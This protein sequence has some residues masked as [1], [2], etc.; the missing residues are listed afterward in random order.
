MRVLSALLC[1]LLACSSERTRTDGSTDTDGGSDSGA[2]ASADPCACLPG[3]H[4]ENIFVISADGE[5]WRFNPRTLDFTFVVGPVCAGQTPF[6]M[7]V[8]AEG[9]AWINIIDSL[10][11]LNLDLLAPS[12]CTD[13]TYQ[14]R[15]PEFGLFGM[16][17][18]TRSATDV[19]ADLFV[20]TYSGDGSFDEGPD[21]GR[22]GV[23]DPVGG[24]LTP[25]ASNNFDGGELTGTGDGRLFGFAGVAPVKLIEFDRETGGTLRE[26]PL[27]GVR[28]TNS[29]AVAFFGGDIY[30][31][32][33]ATAPECSTCLDAECGA[34]LDACEDDAVCSEH[35]DCVLA[36]PMFSDECGGGLSEEMVRCLDRCEACTRG[37]VARTSRV[38]R[39]DL[40]ESDGGGLSEPVEEAP[41][42]I[43]G[44]AS[45]PCVPVG[46]I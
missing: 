44:A 3:P 21:L 15:N 27:D 24:A 31:F 8:D 41:I 16:S 22:L 25:L 2:D 1:F 45:S 38:L 11:V 4:T 33:E 36:T 28:K 40:D 29:S 10:A 26:I 32:T 46:P 9:V 5:I 18:A 23:I 30:L 42:R 6:S 14:R 12:A 43:V 37:S 39:Y 13:S 35:L 17:F 19:C 34:A 20:M 7:G